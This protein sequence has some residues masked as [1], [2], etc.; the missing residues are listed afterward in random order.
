M[1]MTKNQGRNIPRERGK[2]GKK[3]RRRR[4]LFSLLVLA[5][6]IVYMPAL[7]N[8]LFSS[9]SDIA[10]IRN[11]TLEVTTPLKGVLVRKEQLLISPGSGF[12][13]PTVPYGERLVPT[14]RSPP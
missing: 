6:V 2:L 8:W 13:V 1:Q 5:L 14:R 3:K 9:N 10:V 12:L 11:D 7:W 4:R